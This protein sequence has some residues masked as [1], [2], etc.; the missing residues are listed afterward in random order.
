MNDFSFKELYSVSLKATYPMEINNKKD[1]IGE[2]S[3][4]FDNIQLANFN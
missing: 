3:T 1:E 2:V 4:T